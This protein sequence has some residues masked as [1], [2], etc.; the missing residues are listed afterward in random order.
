MRNLPAPIGESVPFHMLLDEVSKVAK[1]NKPVL[2]IGERGTGKEL[3]A[4]R[5]HYLSNQ[6]DD[7][8]VKLNCATLSEELLDSELFGHEAGAFTGAIKKHIGRFEKAKKGTIFLDEIANTSLR[9]QE[10]LLRVIEYGEFERVGG[11]ETLYTDTRIVAATNIDLPTAVKKGE[12]RADLLDRLAFDVLT[13]PPLRAR[14]GD[15]LI[16]ATHFALNMTRDLGGD[17]FPGFSKELIKKLD[18]YEWPGNIRELKN[19]IERSVY[20]SYPLETPIDK[21]QL[22]PF[23]SQYR[24]VEVYEEDTGEIMFLDDEI[25]F[26]QKVLDFE[27]KL[28]TQSL[29]KFQKNK[30][31]TA[32][33]LNLTYNQLRGILRKHNIV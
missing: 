14:S 29:Y 23:E 32:K 16:L 22:D 7:V 21:I 13:V 11:S 2:I 30:A 18:H 15:I 26:K 12:F 8:F 19:V 31:L 20:K 1:L 9:L 33:F 28:L 5:I 27:K 25:D 10:K 3:I 4:E 24:P 6:W 17:Y